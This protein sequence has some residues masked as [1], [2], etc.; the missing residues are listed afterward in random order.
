VSEDEDLT[1]PPKFVRKTKYASKKTVVFDEDKRR[2]RAIEHTGAHDRSML[3]V[4]NLIWEYCLTG[5]TDAPLTFMT[6]T[7]SIPVEAARRYLLLIPSGEWY[8][9]K[10]IVQDTTT[11]TVVKRHVDIVA[12][13]NDRHISSAK[14]GMAKAIEFLTKMKIEERRDKYG[15]PY[16]H[17]FKPNDLR[18][19]MEVIEKAQKIHRL[20]LGLNADEGSIQIWQ[21][22]TNTLNTHGNVHEGEHEVKVLE[23]KLTYDEIKKLIQAEEKA[24]DGAIDVEHEQ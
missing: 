7:K 5:G 16:F 10:K 3:I 4:D 2:Q 6:T 15:R 11:A 8:A 23:S 19:L 24:K 18:Q 14:L 21:N 22:I 1:K 20:A 17:G 13:M 12:E 9:R